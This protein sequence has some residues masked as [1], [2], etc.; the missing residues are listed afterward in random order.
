MQVYDGLF[1]PIVKAN[2][3]ASEGP[4]GVLSLDMS[5]DDSTL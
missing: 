2:W 4:S 5:S 3:S 1:S